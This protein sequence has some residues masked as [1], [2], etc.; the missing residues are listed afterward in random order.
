MGGDI[1]SRMKTRK[2][3]T[4]EKYH[5]LTFIRMTDQRT[6]RNVVW[7]LKC[8]CGQLTYQI[9]Y[10][11]VK[12]KVQTCALST[13]PI[14][15]EILSVGGR[16]S[17]IDYSGKRVG[18][19][20]FIQPTDMYR[21]S[22]IVWEGICDCGKQVY[23]VPNNAKSCGCLNDEMRKR[24]GKASKNVGIRKHTPLISAARIVWGRNYR[25]C[26]FDTFFALSQQSC[27]YCGRAPHREQVYP[28]KHTGRDVLATFVFNG[29][30]RMDNNKDHTGDNIVSCCWDCNHMKGTRTYDEFL[31]HVA[32]MYEFRFQKE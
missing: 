22:E 12:G 23:V 27:H 18:R 6:N 10:L 31:L 24:S 25:E 13:C 32:R 29:L 8:D 17:A 20:V 9:A 5:Y 4:G 26:D 15:K 11:V 14:Y 7:E 3:W 1:R 19:L 2:D 16:K 28:P 21:Q 30:D